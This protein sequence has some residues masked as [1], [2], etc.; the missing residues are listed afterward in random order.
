MI[1]GHS[2]RVSDALAQ[3]E[4]ASVPLATRGEVATIC[5]CSGECPDGICLHADVSDGGGQGARMPEIRLRA[6]ELALTQPARPD[7]PQHGRDARGV[8]DGRGTPQ[9]AA[10]DGDR[11][12]G[13]DPTIRRHAC[14]THAVGPDLRGAP[15]RWPRGEARH[16]AHQEGIA[17]RDGV[18]GRQ[19]AG[20]A[21]L[22]SRERVGDGVAHGQGAGARFEHEGGF[23]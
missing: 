8:R 16:F 10:P 18:G 13:T 23:G 1:G 11:G 19:A 5:A 17:P 7:I 20:Y 21:D 12:R 4:G 9:G 3:G 6:V 15:L 2:A 14:A 22:V